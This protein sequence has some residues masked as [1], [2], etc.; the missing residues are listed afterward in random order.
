MKLDESPAFPVDFSSLYR[1]LP[2]IVARKEIA[3]YLGGIISKGYLANLDSEGQ[4]PKRIRIGRHVG[5]LRE[6]LIAWLQ[7]RSSVID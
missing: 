4:G 1:T 7:A 5:Y 3:R 6:D 2:P